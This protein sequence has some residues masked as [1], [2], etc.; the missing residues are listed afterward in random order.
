MSIFQLISKLSRFLGAS[1]GW[2]NDARLVAAPAQVLAGRRHRPATS[3]LGFGPASGL[4]TILVLASLA[5]ASGPARADDFR[6]NGQ[7]HVDDLVVSGE[8]QRIAPV[9]RDRRVEIDL[10]SNPDPGDFVRVGDRVEL[11]FRTTEDCFVTIISIDANGQAQRLFPRRGDDGWVRAGRVQ[12]LPG[13]RDDYDLRFTGPIGEE[14]V[15]AVA[16][17]DPV[18]HYYPDWLVIGNPRGWD[19]CHY[20]YGASDLYDTGWCVGDPLPEIYRFTERLVPYPHRRDTYS[21]AWIRFDVGRRAPV[22]RICNDCG[23]RIDHGHD[24]G[25]GYFEIHVGIGRG[26]FDFYGPRPRPRYRHVVCRTEE[27]RRWN[28]IFHEPVGRW[29]SPGDV[30]HVGRND[31]LSDVIGRDRKEPAGGGY[32]DGGRNDGRPDGHSM[33][34]DEY[35][36]YREREDGK[37][38]RDVEQG[39]VRDGR[40][41]VS[42]GD[43]G[44][45]RDDG[46]SMRDD[47]GSARDDRSPKVESGR[48][49]SKSDSSV[50]KS[51]SSSSSVEASSSGKNDRTSADRSSRGKSAETDKKADKKSDGRSDKKADK[52]SDGKSGEK[53][54]ESG[55]RKR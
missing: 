28:R 44:S 6:I 40:G 47:R 19:D 51:R 54:E 14:Y 42:D 31:R 13:R 37:R 21:A 46:G 12:A 39:S 30:D 7:I 26:V 4:G 49:D 16:S 2:R 27:P 50:G 43:R 20:S 11:F 45:V 55:R 32:H 22:W 1:I 17:L 34:P 25:H 48:R 36:K 41:S 24:C 23:G 10:W 33:T 15:F 9:P 5:L 53:N 3:G 8:Y 29:R 38:D 18:A 52:D 35:R